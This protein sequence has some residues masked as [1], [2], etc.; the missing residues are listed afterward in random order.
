V[1]VDQRDARLEHTDSGPPSRGARGWT[2]ICPHLYD[3]TGTWRATRP[4]RE[5]RCAAVAPPAPVRTDKQR[6]HCLVAA[7][8][9]CPAYLGAAE[10]RGRLLGDVADAGRGS[11][12]VVA[13]T[14]PVLV[15]RPGA[16]AVA[17]LA[18]RTSLPQVGLVVLMVLGIVALALARFV[19][20]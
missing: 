5:H 7:H 3:V 12:R 10:I 13:R 2:D 8:V 18:L 19:N 16:S 4:T 11:G 15:E 9:E 1:I 6:R 14:T 20:P 17:L